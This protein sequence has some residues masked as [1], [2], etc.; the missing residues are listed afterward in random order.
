MNPTDPPSTTG[1][2]MY[3]DKFG[4]SVIIE[5]DVQ[6]MKEGRFQVMTN[7]YQSRRGLGGYP[8][9]RHEIAKGMLQANPDVTVDLF[10]RVLAATHQ[11]HEVGASNPTVYSN[12]YDLKEGEIHIYHYHNFTNV[13][14]LNLAE[15]LRKGPHHYDLSRP[16]S[17]TQWPLQYTN[18]P[19]RS[20]RF[21]ACWRTVEYRRRATHFA[22]RWNAGDTAHRSN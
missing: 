21:A 20:P 4:Q 17:Q 13:V 19:C 22:D 15:E 11:E 7:F 5:G 18:P 12:I 8:C 14:V 1:A 10:R 3:A 16:F 2:F 6:I 9:K